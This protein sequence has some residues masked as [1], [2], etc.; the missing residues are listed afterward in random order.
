MVQFDPRPA[1]TCVAPFDDAAD[2]LAEPF[3]KVVLHA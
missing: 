3:T 1:L 2:V